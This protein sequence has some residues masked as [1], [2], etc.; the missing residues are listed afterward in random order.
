MKYFEPKRYQEAVLK[1]TRIYFDACHS[2]GNAATAFSKAS[3]TLWQK[4]LGYT[5]LNGFPIDMPYFCLRIPTGG[6]KTW[7]AAKSVPLINSYLLRNEHSV[8]L[9]LVPSRQIRD[10][11]LK[12][13]KNA[14]HPLNA[15]LREAGTITVLSLDEAQSVTRATLDTSTTV[16][17][18][19]RQAFQVEDTEN[20]KV[21]ESS[22]ALQHH[23]DG[24]TAEQKAELLTD[25][26]GETVPY[27][28][29]NMLRLRRPF[30]I[31]DEAHNNRTELGFDTIAKFR[32]SGIME[33]TATPDLQKTPSNVLHSVSASELKAED[34]IKLPIRLEAEPNWQQC[35]ADAI[36]S[37]NTLQTLAAQEERQGANYL[38]PIVLIQ[39]EPKR[40]AVDTRDVYAVKE[41]LIK[42]HQIPES[43][44]IIATGSERGLEQIDE[45]F[46]LGVADPDCP[47]KYIITQKALA[48]G[49]DCPSAYILV[50]ITELHSSTAVEQLLG[51]IL[52]QPDAQQRVAAEL[53][54]SYAFVVSR[55]FTDTA[56]A[57][58]DRLVEGA[59]FERRNV[60]DFVQANKPE[61]GRLDLSS[62]RVVMKPVELTLTTKPDLKNVSKPVKDKVHW[63]NKSKTLTITQP[64][65]KEEA[66]EL[67]TSV[68]DPVI[69]NEIV[70]AAE[71]SRTT[72]LEHFQTPAELRQRFAIPQL[73]VMIQGELQL[74]D[75]PE[76]LDYPWDLS[77]YDA[78][79]T[80]DELNALDLAFKVNEGGEIDV[81]DSG[82]VT[83][84]FI[85]DLQRDLGLS[86]RPEHWNA[87]KVRSWIC[88]NLPDDSITH[89]SKL[90]FVSAWTSKLQDIDKFDLARLNQQKFQ[91]R[92]LL[93][94]RIKTLRKL[95][96]TSIYQ[97]TLFGE[98]VND[99]VFVND[100]YTFVFNPQVYSP[101]QYYDPNTSEYGHYKFTKHYYGQIGEFDSKEEF[102]CACWLDQQAEK[103][104]I[105]FWVRNLVNKEGCSFFL[106][107]ADGRFFPDFICKLSD[108][109]ILVVEYKGGDRYD[110]PKVKAD[111]DIG[112]LWAA[113]SSE[114]CLFIMVKDKQ[115]E[116]VSKLISK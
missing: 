60:Q 99:Q 29:A 94:Q 4:S 95:A 62:G 5:S 82:K 110:T 112:E 73:A 39:A 27:S 71:V 11:T 31:V 103:G 115:W 90:A 35:L 8:I 79:P 42:N 72:A 13:L 55:S 53:N 97:Q 32:P 44:I 93:E 111:R 86:Y 54:Q 49:W 45:E 7:L 88:G 83:T 81:S 50:S 26:E 65:S 19:T 28:L 10:Q 76:A 101:S 85:K 14:N 75:D 107:K 74:F 70:K 15:A 98:N 106:Q 2:E 37:R 51:R 63:N 46:P 30:V 89:S 17:V 114:R 64:V 102:E 48:E 33:L 1:S 108:G 22:G 61:Q 40:K 20:R 58:R 80:S 56:N 105:K 113:Q 23:F 34:M 25:M 84:R 18:A 100:S 6:G 43:E 109:R 52:R 38:R 41:E 116:Q 12:G 9:W 36:S 69:Q 47:V 21:Y 96:V 24:L 59:G 3:H 66:E 87:T 57:L 78:Y 92:N 91:I 16:I 67:K 104:L 68:D 77:L